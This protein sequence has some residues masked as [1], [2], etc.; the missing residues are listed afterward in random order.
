MPFPRCEQELSYCRL[1]QV[2]IDAIMEV[3]TEDPELKCWFLDKPYTDV[4]LMRGGTHQTQVLELEA[5][6]KAAVR[7]PIF[8]WWHNLKMFAVS[9]KDRYRHNGTMLAFRQNLEAC[10]LLCG[11]SPSKFVHYSGAF[12]VKALWF[13]HLLLETA[14]TEFINRSFVYFINAAKY[15]VADFCMP[16][17]LWTLTNDGYLC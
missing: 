5:R 3:V 14:T 9:P 13:G 6:Q 8:V 2:A 10:R 17:C 16:A 15:G 4:Y 11:P 12:V 1:L 7:N